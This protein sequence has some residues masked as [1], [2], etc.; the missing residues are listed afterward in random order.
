M[1]ETWKAQTQDG[2][3]E[4]VHFIYGCSLNDGGKIRAL[5]ARLNSLQHPGLVPMHVIHAEAGRLIVHGPA[6]L[7]TCATA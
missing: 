3:L 7:D 4:L 5:A 1:A 6:V 2:R